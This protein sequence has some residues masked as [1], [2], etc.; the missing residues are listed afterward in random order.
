MNN[1][2]ELESVKEKLSEECGGLIQKCQIISTLFES[3][4]PL[5]LNSNGEL[6]NFK[7]EFNE[8][9]RHLYNF[10]NELGRKEFKIGVIG[11]E[12]AGKSSLINAWIAADLLPTAQERC[13]YTTVEVRSCMNQKEQKV[14]IEYYSREEF[15]SNRREIEELM[16]QSIPGSVSI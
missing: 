2:E 7:R 13:T 15:E 3:I 8:I 16:D 14:V 1:F 12:K 9:E 6:D 11:R 5:I 10:K 4:Q